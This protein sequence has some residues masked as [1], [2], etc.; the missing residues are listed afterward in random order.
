MNLNIVISGP[1]GAGKG[2]L[3]REILKNNNFLKAVS[4][5]TRDMRSDEINKLDYNFISLKE[6]KEKLEKN[7]FF[8]AVEYDGNYYGILNEY[9]KITDKHKLFDIVVSSGINL[10]KKYPDNTVLI[11][12]LPSNLDKLN[13]QRGNRGQNRLD[14]GKKELELA[15]RYDYLIIND[16][17]ENMLKQFEMIIQITLYNSIKNQYSFL[18]TFYEVPKQLIKTK[19]REGYLND[20]YMA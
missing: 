16:T 15:K 6:F 13:K 1:S 17:K 10:K 9:L 20:I 2:T 11:Y 8:E 12:V 5:T 14:I 19:E 4:C 18:D 7:D 3:I